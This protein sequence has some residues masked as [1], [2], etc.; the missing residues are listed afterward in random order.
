MMVKSKLYGTVEQS[1]ADQEIRE[2]ETT[3]RT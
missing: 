1:S 3:V 2:S